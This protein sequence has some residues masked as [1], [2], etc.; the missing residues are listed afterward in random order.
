[1]AIKGNFSKLISQI[2]KVALRITQRVEL[3]DRVMSEPA[4]NTVASDTN[5][6]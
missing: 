4:D 2:M 1:M 3:S 6:T 5:K